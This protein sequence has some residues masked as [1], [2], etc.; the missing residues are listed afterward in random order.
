[1][2]HLFACYVYLKADNYNTGG[3]AIDKVSGERKERRPSIDTTEATDLKTIE[4]SSD[5]P[6]S[7]SRSAGDSKI[8][9]DPVSETNQTDEAGSCKENIPT[10]GTDI[11]TL[12]DDKAIKNDITEPMSIENVCEADPTDN[13]MVELEKTKAD[14]KETSAECNADVD[15]SDVNKETDVT[16]LKQP[17]QSTVGA[18]PGANQQDN[19]TEYDPTNIAPTFNNHAGMVN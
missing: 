3:V 4:T 14:S 15:P 10:K 19:K 2:V 12:A 18:A 16:G 5:V 1:M 13:D 17:T 9:C 6:C 8:R 11:A 7:S